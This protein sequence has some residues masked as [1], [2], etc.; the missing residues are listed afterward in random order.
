MTCT[1]RWQANLSWV[2]VLAQTDK[3]GVPQAPVWAPLRKLDLGKALRLEPNAFF[4]FFF[5]Q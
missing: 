1:D 5:G 3:R 4:H 2:F